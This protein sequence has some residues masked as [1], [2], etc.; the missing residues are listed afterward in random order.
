MRLY[1]IKGERSEKVRSEKERERERER[2]EEEASKV[3]GSGERSA[4]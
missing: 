3:C 1:T 2:K 4:L